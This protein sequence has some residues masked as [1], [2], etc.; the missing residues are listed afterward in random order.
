MQ[1]EKSGL[2]ARYAPMI[3]GAREARYTAYE[4]FKSSP[5]GSEKR[6]CREKREW[7]TK[8]EGS[9]VKCTSEWEF[10]SSDPRFISF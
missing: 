7:E 6:E 1:T 4:L 8:V 5:L 2:L 3:Q 9:V 10:F